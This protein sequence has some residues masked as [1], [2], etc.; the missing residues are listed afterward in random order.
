MAGDDVTWPRYTSDQHTVLTFDTNM[1]RDSAN[2]DIDWEAM[3]EFWVAIDSLAQWEDEGMP[4]KQWALS[5]DK[6][7]NR[8]AVPAFM[9]YCVIDALATTVFFSKITV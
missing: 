4:A 7:C 6:G 1:S 5:G 9:Q 2:D 8:S 3:T